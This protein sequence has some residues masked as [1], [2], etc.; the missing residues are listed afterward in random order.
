M[1]NLAK[2]DG[3]TNLPNHRIFQERLEDSI[4]RALRNNRPLSLMLMDID[5]FKKFND[6]YG[7]STGDAVLKAVSQ[8]IREHIREVDFPA[9][10][11]GEEFVLILEETNKKKAY[12]VGERIRYAIEKNDFFLNNQHLKITISGGIAEFPTDTADK[13]ELIELADSALY[14]AKKNGRNRLEIYAKGLS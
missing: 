8:V 7:H 11:G 4:K 9:R 10:Y 12:E 14:R 5:Y 1:S 13:K 3:L 2:T 6:S